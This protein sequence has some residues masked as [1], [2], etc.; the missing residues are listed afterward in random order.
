MKITEL[1]YDNGS[2]DLWVYGYYMGAC[3]AI[4]ICGAMMKALRC[5]E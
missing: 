1:T 5:N 4:T 2:V 3:M